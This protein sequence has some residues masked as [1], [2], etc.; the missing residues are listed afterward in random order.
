MIKH[1]IFLYIAMVILNGC[2]EE[3]KPIS[4]SVDTTETPHLS[5]WGN[6]AQQLLLKWVPLTSQIFDDYNFPLSIELKI[7][8]SEEGIA[9]AD[10]N[11]IVVSSH[12]IE[13]YPQD[14]GLV[15]HEGVHVV[16]A[17]PNFEPGWLT[18]GIADYIRWSLF[19]E[20]PQTWF[21]K[22]DEVKGYEA[23][24]QTTGG[25]LLWLTD[26]HNK[27]IV[28]TLHHAMKINAYDDDIFKRE[29]GFSVD[30]LWTMYWQFR[31]K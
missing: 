24:Y 8:N 5:Q 4:V 13:K 21:P 25:F 17:Y 7:Q 6:D 29:T 10:S 20:K 3:M 16:Q 1:I 19:E 26:N 15:V 14:I 22:G 2:A 27:N 18:E 28:K 11:K 30:T 9:Y 23:A 31:N 12:W